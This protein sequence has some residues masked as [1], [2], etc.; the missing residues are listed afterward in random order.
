VKPYYEHGG[1]TIYHGSALS[2][3]EWTRADVMVTDPPYGMNYKSGWSGEFVAGDKHTRARDGVLALWGDKPALVFGRWNLPKPIGTRALLTWDKGDWPG[4]GDLSLPWGPSTE[5]VYVLGSGFVGKRA[6]TVIR[7]K[8]LG[9]SGAEHPTEKPYGLWMKLLASCP[10]GSVVDPFMGVGG[11]V[12][13]ARD[14]GRTAIGVELEER[15]CE[16]AAKRLSQDV[17]PLES[18]G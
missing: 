10:S 5:E 12:L 3:L 1:I 6:G 16:I 9:A 4:M 7:H 2:F 8:R 13:A 17:L 15:Y 14:S 11:L 18:V